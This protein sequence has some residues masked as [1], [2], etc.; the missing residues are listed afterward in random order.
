MSAAEEAKLKAKA[1][2]A[3]KPPLERQELQDE[4]T[5]MS[6]T[7]T[8]PDTGTL[9]TEL[10]AS[11]L[12]FKDAEGE[13][14][15]IDNTLKADPAGKGGG[16]TNGANEFSLELPKSLTEPVTIADA[17]D[18]DSFVSLELA[19]QETPLKELDA[20]DARR[21]SSAEP[22]EVADT[23]GTVKDTEVT[24]AQALPGVDVAYAALGDAVKET[25]TVASLADLDALPGGSLSFTVKTGPGMD[26]KVKDFGA[27]DV[28]D[29]EGK[30]AFEIPRPIM[31]DNA[32]EPSTQV[33][34]LVQKAET[35]AWT[36][37]LTPDREWLAAE[38]R[39]WP[40]VIDPS[41]GVGAPMTTCTLQSNRDQAEGPLCVGDEILTQWTAESSNQRRALIRFD[42]LLD[43][44]PADAQ[45]SMAR[46]NLTPLAPNAGEVKPPASSVDVRAVPEEFTVTEKNSPTW[47]NRAGTT[48]W[49]G[50]GATGPGAG[51]GTVYE[52]KTLTPN[53][54]QQYL[55]VTRLVQ[56]WTEG[57]IPHH[58]FLLQK[59]AAAA[60]TPDVGG[61]LR[62]GSAYATGTKVPS[63]Y[64]EWEHRTGV[65]KG[66]TAVVTEEL[67][68]RTSVSVNPATGN[69]AVTTREL[70]IAGAGVDLNVAHT[71]QSL[72]TS[73]TNVLGYGWTNSLTGTR[74]FPYYGGTTGNAQTMFY[75]DGAGGQWTY[76][77]NKEVS[78][79]WKRPMGLDKDLAVVDNNSAYTLTDRQSQTVERFRNIGTTEDQ[80][81]GLDTIADRNGNKITFNYDTSVR[82][83]I[84]NTLMLRSVTDTRGRELTVT[85]YDGYYDSFKTDDSGRQVLYDV[86]G[87]DLRTYTDAAGGTVTYEYD[88]D[89]RVT[90][91]VTPANLRTEMA[92]DARGRITEL[93]R[94]NTS[95]G[96]SVW[97]F[98][99]SEFERNATGAPATKTKVTDPNGN[100]TEYTSDGRGRTSKATN[101][102]GKSTSKT[103]SPNDDVATSTGATSASGGGA[104]TSTAQYEA[105]ESGDTY[106][107]TSTKIPTGAGVNLEWGQGAQ[108]YNIV[109]EKDS[110]NNVTTY[111]YNAD[112]NQS[113]AKKA[114]GSTTVRIYHGDTDPAYGGTVHCGPNNSADTKKGVLC[115]VRDPEYTK[116]DSRATT[117]G[118]RTAYQ[119][120]TKGELAKMIPPAGG[121]LKEQTY[122]YDG[123][124][125]LQ[126]LTDGNGHHTYY[127]YDKLDRLTYTQ[128]ADRSVESNWYG[129]ENKSNGWLRSLTEYGP[130]DGPRIRWTNYD[131]DDLGR[132]SATNNWD[133]R[134]SS[135]GYDKA[136]NL[137]R[138]SDSGGDVTYTYN[139][140]DHLTSVTMPGGTCAGRTYANPGDAAGKCITFRVDD[141]GR[142]T[143]TKYP[144]GTSVQ[145]TERDD[146]GRIQRIIATAGAGTATEEPHLDLTYTHTQG[147]SDSH[148][149]TSVTDALTKEKTTYTHDNQDRLTIASTTPT[150]GG[151]A[152]YY[153]A[154][155]YDKA[156][157]RTKYYLTDKATCS[158]ANPTATY[159]YNTANQLTNATGKTPTGQ[160]IT[161]TGFSYDGNGN[162]TSAKSE[163][164]RSTTYND[165][166]QA[167]SF[168]PAA[169]SKIDQTYTG[170]GNGDRL[171]SG[172][173]SFMSSP[174]SPA[175]AWSKTGN[176]TTWTV[177]D[178]E[179]S[180]LAIRIGT[181]AK[182]ASAYYS[183]TDNL[184]NVRAM[185]TATDSAAKAAYTY[186]AY[187]DTTSST[188]PLNQPYQYGEGYT[189]T[190]TGLAKLDIRYYDP[191]HGRFTQHDPTQQEQHSYLYSNGCPTTY[192]DPTGALFGSSTCASLNLTAA[193][194][195]VLTGVSA[196][197]AAGVALINPI[198]AAVIGVGSGVAGAT[199]GFSAGAAWL[200]C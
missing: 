114:D 163:T 74:I 176:E 142:R 61:L 197:L 116:G 73:F 179:G 168:T 76:L 147:S 55:E 75:R 100:A 80:V 43:V 51:T 145:T 181:D 180:L 93:R 92:Y 2:A 139:K 18:A 182:S 3:A 68:D 110:R 72:N 35:G 187:G 194:A 99:Y 144:G 50:V 79:T 13:W 44:I 9:V 58:G 97:T 119:Y 54:Q 70:S 113:E 84:D 77:R 134:N 152:S 83:K 36:L 90:A 59:R 29:A 123:L 89:H 195:T 6:R 193:R 103:Y 10:S 57:T 169:G 160:P 185:V 22:P 53:G 200:F 105:T 125:R 21:G 133:D 186:S 62:F 12:N 1:L 136:S 96:D 167:S 33:T 45:I 81:W 95:G 188:G 178:P 87:N 71:S 155:C 64:V 78:N 121:S 8:D 177:R 158:T 126:T 161:G 40:V 88:A 108:T 189:D 94:K 151:A 47:T 25:A 124:S 192:N 159:T 173:T 118:H 46:L 120:N 7:F 52:R 5:R 138:Y 102:L 30:V 153:E 146:A 135:M 183:F 115:E 104:Q 122:T 14:Q 143:G 17:R 31:K 91:V 165:R 154:F 38:E 16:W 69:A 66:N 85:N 184:N 86:V 37:T 15:P 132:L 171:T 106:R 198:V 101:A 28:L 128:H 196:S 191:T 82:S 149:V 129:D 11:P 98:E 172:T 162:E 56:D 190:T 34:T 141:D 157:N 24:Y 164:G 131:R 175:P 166:D 42:Q 150:S 26:L 41:I 174:L 20:G 109:S 63:M 4:R 170:T 32:G 117:G 148:L 67:S 23:P 156:G 27:V 112:G 199:A 19:P 48:T 137:T 111:K 127:G 49:K 130:N 107:M 60:G 140:A 39:R 65:R